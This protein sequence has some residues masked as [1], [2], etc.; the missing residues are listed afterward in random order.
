MFNF[1]SIFSIDTNSKYCKKVI[2]KQHLYGEITTMN[3][4]LTSS[5]KLYISDCNITK[6]GTKLI[7]KL[8]STKN[9]FLEDCQFH[10]F[11]A[12]K[13]TITDTISV[14]RDVSTL[15]VLNIS[16]ISI[17]DEAANDVVAV[18]YNNPLLEKLNISENK[19]S[20]KIVQIIVALSKVDTIKSLIISKNKITADWIEHVAFALGQCLELKEL[21]ISHNFLTFTAILKLAQTFRAHNN[22]QVLNLSNNITSFYAGSECLVDAI[23]SINQPLV[24]LNVC[25]KN[26]RPRFVDHPP[27]LPNNR[28]D[29]TLQKMYLSKS[30]PMEFPMFQRDAIILSTKVINSTEDCPITNQ[31]VS[32]FYIN[33][34][35]GTYYNK[36]YDFAI[37]I[38]P[39]AVSHGHCVEVKATASHFGPYFFPDKYHPISSYFW[40]SA[41]YTFTIPVYLMLSHHAVINAVEDIDNLCVLQACVYDLTVTSM[42]KLVMKELSNGTYFDFDIRCCIVEVTH[43][44]SFCMA[45][46]AKHIPEYFVAHFY[47]YDKDNAYIAEVYFCPD[48]NNCKSVSTYILS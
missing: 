28:E 11:Y 14:L 34:N 20:S 23:L 22:L 27:P 18:V 17:G 2:E 16:C 46:K 39:G 13:M 41:N 25:G 35:G 42:G 44:C 48:N 43:F 6:Q 32:S 38:P 9:T 30:H 47:T 19:F 24:Y 3:V 37:V 1:I 31:P 10:T 26:I 40:V 4:Q 29:Y 45:K 5:G 36:D 33:H 8:L 21:D 7:M 15:K 12:I